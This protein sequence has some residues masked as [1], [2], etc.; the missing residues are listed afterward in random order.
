MYPPVSRAQQQNADNTLLAQNN[1]PA[2]PGQNNGQQPA[3][4]KQLTGDATEYNLPGVNLAYGGK[5]DSS[6]M[7]AAM[8]PDRAKNGQTVTVTYTTTDKNGNSVTTTVR[9]VVNDTGPFARGSNGK[10]L[11][12]LRPDPKIVI[13]LTP[14]A[15]KAL[16][17]SSNNRVPVTVTVPQP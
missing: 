13:D 14:T 2:A 1:P 3:T 16:T 5:Y 11:Q 12:P 10:A 15:M 17:G 7:A 8:T 6:K 4:T 9:V